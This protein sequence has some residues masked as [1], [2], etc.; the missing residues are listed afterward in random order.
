MFVLF[1]AF[2]HAEINQANSTRGIPF[3]IVAY[4]ILWD[5]LSQNSCMRKVPLA[6]DGKEMH[7]DLLRT[8]I[9]IVLLIKPFVLW[10]SRCRRCP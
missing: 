8:C 2:F 9:A 4:M 6:E 10:R 1:P 7:K 5:S 3:D